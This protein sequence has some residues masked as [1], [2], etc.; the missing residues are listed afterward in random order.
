MISEIVEYVNT[1][2]PAC[3][4]QFYPD[5]FIKACLVYQYLYAENFSNKLDLSQ[6]IYNLSGDRYSLMANSPV[7]A[8]HLIFNLAFKSFYKKYRLG[9]GSIYVMNSPFKES[10]V[11]GYL[12][13]IIFWSFKNGV[14]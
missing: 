6:I 12:L 8:N 2:F 10:E 13:G 7:I 11:L 14:V 3:K 1:H 5:N 4:T 9:R